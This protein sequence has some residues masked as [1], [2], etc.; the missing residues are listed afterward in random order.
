MKILV[1]GGAGFIGSHIV[2]AYVA[3]GHSVVVVDNLSTGRRENIHPRAAFYHVDVRSPDLRSVFEKEL[4]EIVNH[5]A[6][7]M[8]IRRSVADPVDDAMI[9]IVGG[10]RLFESC[11]EFRVRKVVFASTGGAVYGEQ[12]YF[13]ADED[14]PTKPLSPYGIAKLSSE[15]YLFYY[16][17]IFG[18][19][20]TILRYANIYGPRQNPHGEAGVVAIFAHKMLAGQ[21]PII[22]GDGTQTRDYAFVGD[23]VRANQLAL[24]A[25]G[26]RIYNVGTGIET[27]V[28]ALFRAL[29]DRLAPS[30]N[31]SFGPAKPGEQLRSVI[32][33]ARIHKELGWRPLVYVEEGLE[34]TVASFKAGS[35]GRS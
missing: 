25:R 14:H 6:A 31:E 8:D 16:H 33:C 19:D 1:T 23:V 15:K 11:R 7:Q 30:C 9:N 5:H 24:D 13:P 26:F 2:D 22:N 35:E 21:Q 10:L 32:S 34:R 12:R 4:P 28:R 3:D 27:D 29:R 18:L 17:Q 20:V